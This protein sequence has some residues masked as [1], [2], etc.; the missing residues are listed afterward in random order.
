MRCV[1]R[2]ASLTCITTFFSVTVDNLRTPAGAIVTGKPAIVGTGMCRVLPRIQ[3]SRKRRSNKTKRSSPV[4]SPSLRSS[5]ALD[6][7]Y[8]PQP[9]TATDS[10]FCTK[11]EERLSVK[12]EQ[13]DPVGHPSVAKKRKTK[14]KKTDP[15]KKPKFTFH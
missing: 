13:D 7:V 5:F 1:K 12:Q 6:P 11:K 4:T 10:S 8:D 2:L 3:L 9:T 15:V 14:Q